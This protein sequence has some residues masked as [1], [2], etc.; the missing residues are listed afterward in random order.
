MASLEADIPKSPTECKIT[1]DAS[2]KVPL[3]GSPASVSQVGSGK[4]GTCNSLP[5]FRM[6]VEMY[7]L[8]SFVPQSFRILF[9]YHIFHWSI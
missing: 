4:R 5:R 6:R 3:G 7:K 2:H 8:K 1:R 9:N